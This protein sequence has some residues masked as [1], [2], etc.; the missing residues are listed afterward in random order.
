MQGLNTCI[1]TRN[2]VYLLKRNKMTTLEL[3]NKV[4]GRIKKVEDDEI[5]N[6]VYKLLDENFD[7]D[8]IYSL[9]DNHKSAI[10]LASDQIARGEYLTNDEANKGIDE[11]LN[12]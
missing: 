11:W 2:F 5:L 6:D 4:I 12:K 9:S 7:D 3:R 1:L 10:K 8:E